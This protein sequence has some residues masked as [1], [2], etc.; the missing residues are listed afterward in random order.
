MDRVGGPAYLAELIERTPTAANVE[1]YAR[2]VREATEKRELIKLCIKTQEKAYSS[3]KP[4]ELA[5]DLIE[6]ITP[7]A[8]NGAD[9][10]NAFIKAGELLTL[11]IDTETPVIGGG[12]LPAGGGMIIAGE[13]GIGKSLLRTELAINLAMGWDWLSFT[14]PTAR[15]VLIVSFENPLGSEKFRLQRMLVGLQISALPDTLVFADPKTRV[16]LK[17]KKDR[18]RLLGI[19]ERSKAAVVIYDPLSSLH[20]AQENDNIEIRTVL[21]TLSEINR[22]CGTSCIVIHHYGKPTPD[23][24]N[25]HRTR[26]ASSIKDWCDTLMGITRRAHEHKTLR[27]LEFHKVRHGA[28]PKPILLERDENYV[29]RITEKDMLCPPEKVMEILESLGGR[30][31]K[32]SELLNAISTELRCTSRSALNFLKNAV[33]KTVREFQTGTKTKGYEIDR[34]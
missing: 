33:G 25:E 9:R 19:V 34:N 12:I 26:G 21:D 7:I 15:R 10:E 13:S 32:Q 30:V 24:R 27:L 8:R 6:A 16:D 20:S 5:T 18:T 31:E 1:Y 4:A 23:Q 2:L 22:R 14:V 29:H 3:E 28:Q 11:R 17:L